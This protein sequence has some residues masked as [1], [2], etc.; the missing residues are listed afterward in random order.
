[1]VQVLA[2]EVVEVSV[3]EEG[4]ADATRA[5]GISVY[6][7]LV[8]VFLY[9]TMRARADVIHIYQRRRDMPMSLRIISAFG[10]IKP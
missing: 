5:S 9:G 6:M 10:E 8:L 2:V 4:M 1:M 3:V 7:L